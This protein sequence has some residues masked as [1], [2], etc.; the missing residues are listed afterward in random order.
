[1]AFNC[2]LQIGYLV[3]LFLILTSLKLGYLEL[4]EEALVTLQLRPILLLLVLNKLLQLLTS[5]SVLAHD[6]DQICASKRILRLVLLAMRHAVEHLADVTPFSLTLARCRVLIPMVSE[7]RSHAPSV[8]SA[9]IDERRLAAQHTFR[10]FV[11]A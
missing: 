2:L 10:K 5:I 4:L 8:A 7:R 6:S 1:M 3:R 11:N 9:A